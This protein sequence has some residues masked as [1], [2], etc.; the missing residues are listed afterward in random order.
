M[1]KYITAFVFLALVVGKAFAWEPNKPINAVIGWSPGSGND[2]SFR[3]VS[4]QVEKMTNAKFV[5]TY[6]PGAGGAIADGELIRAPAD[7]YNL[8]VASAP[9][10]TATDKIF[11]PTKTWDIESFVN[12]I[13]YAGSTMA[14]FTSADD[15]V[16][17][18]ADMARVLRTEKVAIGD[19]GGA[20]RLTNELLQTHMGFKVDYDR[21]VHVTYKGN[22]ETITAVLTKE[23]RFGASPLATVIE[24]YKAGKIK[25]IALTS[26]KPLPALPNIPVFSS[27]YPDLSYNLI[28]GITM[29]KDVPTD[30]VKWYEHAFNEALKSD[31]VREQLQANS[32]FIDFRTL[33][34]KD[35]T[36]YLVKERK[37][38]APLVDKIVESQKK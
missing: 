19:P 23:I 14:V 31:A 13:G 9:S 17:S 26:P 16:N 10:L 8:V 29:P 4:A 3:I 38:L 11:V 30:V 7:G 24:Q 37:T 33:D 6:R 28:W 15:P 36:N 2:I 12:V 22:P 27:T 1:R 5:I 21:I 20:S 25:I 34:T 32:M 18:V 35:Y